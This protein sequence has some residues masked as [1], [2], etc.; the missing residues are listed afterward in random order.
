MDESPEVVQTKLAD[1][2]LDDEDDELQF[3]LK[4]RQAD[5]L[6]MRTASSIRYQ[7]KLDAKTHSIRVHD[8]CDSNC[9]RDHKEHPPSD[10][11]NENEE[12]DDEYH[13]DVDNILQKECVYLHHWH[14]RLY[15][16]EH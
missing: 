10:E 7:R 14:R 9:S 13:P 4:S 15:E 12:E 6:V 1:V 2:P 16:Q 8:V 11:E 5:N 3:T